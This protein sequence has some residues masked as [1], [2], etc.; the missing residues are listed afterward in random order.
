MED[1]WILAEVILFDAVT[2]KYTDDQVSF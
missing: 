1:Q 2:Q